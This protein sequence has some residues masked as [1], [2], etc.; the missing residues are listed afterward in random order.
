MYV[1]MYVC[2]YVCIYIYTSRYIETGSA[3]VGGVADEERERVRCRVT[4]CD[5]VQLDVVNTLAEKGQH[6]C[7]TEPSLLLSYT[8]QHRG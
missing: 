7:G 2:I 4:E 5:V 3:T 1:Y 8:T 6:C